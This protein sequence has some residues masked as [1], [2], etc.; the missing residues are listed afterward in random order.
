MVDFQEVKTRFNFAAVVARLGL[1]VTDTGNQWRGICPHCKTG[2]ERSLVITEGRGFYCFTAKKGGDQIALVAHVRDLPVKE[3]AEWLA[4]EATVAGSSTSG[5]NP[6]AYLDAAHEAVAAVGL[7]E[8][9]AKKI[10]AGYAPKGILKGSVA[11]PIRDET[12]T[13][14][15]YIGCQ[16]PLLL[17]K[18]FQ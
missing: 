5:M 15:G 7:G 1:T 10:G 12:G 17:P 8:A 6:L 11:I 16:E 9:F 4:T 18:D 3:A 13:L 2:D 14:L